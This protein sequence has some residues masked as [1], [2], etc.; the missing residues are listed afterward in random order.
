M[1]NALFRTNVESNAITFI[2][3]LTL[4]GLMGFILLQGGSMHRADDGTLNV[5]YASITLWLLLFSFVAAGLALL[6]HNRERHSRL[7][8]Q[9]PVT[10][11]QVRLAYW[12]H[13]ALYA[14]IST[15]VLALI[16][17]VAG[18]LPLLDVLLFALL[19]LC[20]AGVVM[21]VLSI[22]TGNSV[23]LIPEEIRRRT[24]V[25]FFLATFVTFLFLLA[26]GFVMSWYIYILEGRE[27][28]WGLLTLLM[29]AVCAALVAW[30]IALFRRRDNYLG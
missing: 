24:I 7:Y 22:V 30:D 21:A 20:H 27:V 10:P 4:N 18:D 15:L 11:L 23:Q 5:P 25:Y 1:I 29:A 17:L 13:A 9:L 3:F 14:G 12:C 28:D 19:Y 16:M 8:A 26:I 6:R 2:V